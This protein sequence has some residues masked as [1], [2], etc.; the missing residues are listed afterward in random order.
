[1][2]KHLLLMILTAA[3]FPSA[4]P[5]A[6]A[7]DAAKG[8]TL[9]APCAACHGQNGEGNLGLNSPALAGQENWYV[10]R[11][12]RNYQKGIRGR[13]AGDMFGAQMAPMANLL[14]G[15]AAIANVAAYLRSLP[16][17]K[18]KPTLQGDA[19]KG[20]I[21]YATCIA[22]HGQN[23]EGNKALNAPRLTGQHDWYLARQ[24]RYFKSGIRGAHPEDIYGAQMPP[25]LGQL[26]DEQA[27]EDVVSYINTLQ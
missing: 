18:A 3:A 23:G 19:A 7:A 27:I 13:G 2:K 16:S 9:Y 5:S 25:M 4:L 24:L 11:Q 22:C 10:A 1:M 15:D 17:I 21:L 26:Q 20:K 8:K 6:Q 12:L 14:Q